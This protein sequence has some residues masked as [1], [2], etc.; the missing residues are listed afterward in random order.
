MTSKVTPRL[1]RRSVT[2]DT[3]TTSHERQTH[4]TLVHPGPT[5]RRCSANC[6]QVAPLGKRAAGRSA[7][8]GSPL[9]RGVGSERIPSGGSHANDLGSVQVGRQL[10]AGLE[11]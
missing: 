1:S 3:D 11:A 10:P 9:P 4:P 2:T 6:P 5:W 8:D 7:V